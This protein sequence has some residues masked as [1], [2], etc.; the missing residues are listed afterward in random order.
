MSQFKRYA[1]YAAN[2][3]LLLIC[4][5][6]VYLGTVHFLGRDDI[7]ADASQAN[8]NAA[9]QWLQD[10]G[11]SQRISGSGYADIGTDAAGNVYVAAFQTDGAG[12]DRARVF[13]MTGAGEIVWERMSTGG[14]ARATALAIGRPSQVWLAGHYERTFGFGKTALQSPHAHSAFLL[15]STPHGKISGQIALEGEVQIYDMALLASRDLL[16]LGQFTNRVQIGDVALSAPDETAPF[17]AAMGASGD[18]R[19]V[20]VAGRAAGIAGDTLG[21]CYVWGAFHETM[22]AGRDTF[23]T[24]GALDQ[25]GFV[26]R[27]SATGEID[28]TWIYGNALDGIKGN[29]TA[30]RVCDGL[31]TAGDRLVLLTMIESRGDA[32]ERQ[33]TVAL[34]EQDSSGTLLRSRE[35]P[36]PA[37]N[38]P[39]HLARGS[40]GILNVSYTLEFRE[41]A[42]RRR[43]DVRH[44]RVDRGLGDDRNARDIR[45]QSRQCDPRSSYARSVG[46]LRGPLPGP[47][48]ATRHEL[49]A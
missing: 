21:N 7:S 26:T 35:L 23:A 10:L 27:L 32:G 1:L 2:L 47:H 34:I 46:L 12:I 22:I 25:D 11:P 14:A 19:L 40:E 42:A 5:R 3:A 29:R 49:R 31:V 30:D 13:K 41:R 43:D 28:R 38:A 4:A 9:Q 6:Y 18:V 20:R 17:V 36:G 33:F 8:P 44:R 39:V 37:A 48:G 24:R 15:D 16:L 45:S